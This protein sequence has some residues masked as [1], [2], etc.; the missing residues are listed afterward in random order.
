VRLPLAVVLL[1]L[2]AGCARAPGRLA[3]RQ[4]C[5]TWSRLWTRPRGWAGTRG[6]AIAGVSG[7]EVLIN[8]TR[9][10]TAF[11]AKPPR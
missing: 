3:G 5:R 9:M 6:V 7:T 2:L 1:A 11:S 4:P 10:G 8:T